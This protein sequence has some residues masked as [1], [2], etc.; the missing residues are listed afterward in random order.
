MTRRPFRRLLALL[1]TVTLLSSQAAMAGFACP[2]TGETPQAMHQAMDEGACHKAPDAGSKTLC[3]K[4]CQD[5]AQ[6]RDNPQVDVPAVPV[7][8]APPVAKSEGWVPVLLA[9]PPEPDRAR[10]TA[11]PPRIKNARFQK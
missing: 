7:H 10:P 9:L 11:P 4:S 6:Q 8:D 1:A 2:L 3:Q 5:E